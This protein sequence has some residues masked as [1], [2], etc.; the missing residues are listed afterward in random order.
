MANK[1]IYGF[2][3]WLAWIVGFSLSFILIAAAWTFLMKY[4]FGVIAG[5][6]LAFTWSVAVF[7]SW[8]IVVIP[9][10]RKKE[11]IWK[12]LDV[13]Q[14]SA[15]DLWLRMISILILGWILTSL[16]WTWY[17]VG[18]IHESP[19]RMTPSFSWAKAV[20]SSWALLLIPFLIVAYRKADVLFD[21]AAVRQ[22]KKTTTFKRYFIPQV[23]RKLPPVLIEKLKS[24]PETLAD[25]HVV[26]VTLKDGRTFEHVFIFK[27]REILGVYDVD[28]LDWD[29]SLI[30][31]ISVVESET[32]PAYDESKWV[33]LDG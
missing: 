9:F 15:V 29:A 1:D 19:L 2:R 14:E 32:L 12:R 10:M 3:F 17:Y 24:A 6:Y 28:Q 21:H 11:Q 13:D 22:A 30:Q 18:A 16:F 26:S 8:L 7:G 20:F 23:K 5:P 4:V 33:R 25:G 27:R 31:D